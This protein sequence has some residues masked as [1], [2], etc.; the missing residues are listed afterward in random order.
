MFSYFMVFSRIPASLGGWIEAAG[1][2][3]NL[4]IFC[5]VLVYIVFGL[6]LD[7]VSMMLITVPVFLPILQ[8][9]GVDGVWFGVFVVIVA[10]IGLITP[11]VGLNIFVIKTQLPDIPIQTLYGGIAP[12]LVVDLLLIALL[13]AFPALALWLPGVLL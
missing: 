12:F 6:F 1:L 13:V 3:A 11:P 2:S 4:V 5:L 9:L 8:A 10:E 7:S